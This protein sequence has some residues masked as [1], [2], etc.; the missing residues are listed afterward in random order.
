VD[1]CRRSGAGGRG[2]QS[3]HVRLDRGESERLN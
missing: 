3:V 1:L 2:I